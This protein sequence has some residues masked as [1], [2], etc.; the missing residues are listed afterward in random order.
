MDEINR[1]TLAFRSAYASLVPTA[2]PEQVDRVTAA[3]ATGCEFR[4]SPAVGQALARLGVTW[5]RH[6]IEAYFDGLDEQYW[7]IAG[8]QPAPRLLRR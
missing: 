8:A 4:H 5:R 1:R 3:V 2:S 6:E 7:T